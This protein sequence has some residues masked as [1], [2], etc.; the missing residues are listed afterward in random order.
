MATCRKA[1]A[2]RLVIYMVGCRA[3]R[4]SSRSC[5]PIKYIIIYLVYFH[6]LCAPWVPNDNDI[7]PAPQRLHVFVARQSHS[8]DTDPSLL[9]CFEYIRPAGGGV[10]WL[11]SSAFSATSL[12]KKSNTFEIAIRVCVRVCARVCACC[13]WFV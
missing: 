7:C 6:N 5:L 4:A 10:S 1:I 12:S 3:R 9:Y 11:S 8:L 13:V 2:V